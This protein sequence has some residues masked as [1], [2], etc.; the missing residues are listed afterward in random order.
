MNEQEVRLID[1]NKFAAGL[2]AIADD[3]CKNGD[4]M[5]AA[6]LRA[7]AINLLGAQQTID[8]DSLRP[9]GRWLNP[10]ECGGNMFG[11]CSIC[12]A[13]YDVEQGTDDGLFRYCPHCGAK[14]D[15]EE[16]EQKDQ[17]D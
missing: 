14:M 17:V 5:I 10:S 4:P 11:P 15:G 2:E 6:T 16:N 13:W 9:H 8:P 1:A 12:G 7:V 3:F